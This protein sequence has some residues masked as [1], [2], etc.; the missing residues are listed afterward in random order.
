MAEII[1]PIASG[2]VVGV[3]KEVGKELIEHIPDMARDI[4]RIGN[5]LFD[6][7]KKRYK[8]SI[9]PE[10][11][12]IEASKKMLLYAE[13]GQKKI[14][15]SED[16]L[17]NEIYK[18]MQRIGKFVDIVIKENETKVNCFGKCGD[19]TVIFIYEIND[20]DTNKDGKIDK[21]DFKLHS[22]FIE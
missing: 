19:K 13:K 12:E 7:I 15:F 1:A 14:P 17:N 8:N 10:Q 16:E 21:I 3:A 22:K 4:N 6:E 20:L 11:M 9:P 5:D 18:K 2:I